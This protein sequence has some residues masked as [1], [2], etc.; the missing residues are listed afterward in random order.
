MLRELKP[1]SDKYVNINCKVARTQLHWP[2]QTTDY[3]YIYYLRSQ[4]FLLPLLYF[5]T[6]RSFKKPKLF[7]ENSHLRRYHNAPLHARVPSPLWSPSR[8]RFT[9]LPFLNSNLCFLMFVSRQ[10]NKCLQISLW[11]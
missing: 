6:L 4:C 5:I 3:S 2:P 8:I 1:I 11:L 7:T 9:R 10:S